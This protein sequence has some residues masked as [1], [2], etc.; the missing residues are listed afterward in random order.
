MRFLVTVPDEMHTLLK[1]QSH[2]RGQTLT[3]LIRQILW[4]WLAAQEAKRHDG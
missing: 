1:C 4:E 2:S 3:G